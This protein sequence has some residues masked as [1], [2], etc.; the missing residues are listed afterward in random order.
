MAAGLPVPGSRLLL[1]LLLALVLLITQAFPVTSAYADEPDNPV[2]STPSK[3]GTSEDNPTTDTQDSQYPA[4]SP[5]QSDTGTE[6]EPGSDDDSAK[7]ADKDEDNAI[8]NSDSDSDTAA[9]ASKELSSSVPADEEESQPDST[10]L[11]PEALPQSPNTGT[12]ISPGTYYLQPVNSFLRVLDVWGASGAD[13]AKVCL[14]DYHGG[15]NQRFTVSQDAQGYYTITNTSSKKALDVWGALAVSGASV[16]QY[17][18]HNNANQ[19]WYAVEESGGTYSFHTALGLSAGKDLAL[20]V[21]GGADQNAANLTIYTYHKGQNQL[22]RLVAADTG[23]T[24]PDP[25]VTIDAQSYYAIVPA[26]AEGKRLDIYGGM[27]EV[28]ARLSSYRY[29][30]GLN[31]IFYFEQAKQQSGYYSIRAANSTYALDIYGAVAHASANVV[32]WPAH[33]G[34]NQLWA[35]KATGTK[36]ADG[37]QEVYILSAQVGQTLDVYGSSTADGAS[38]MAY[39]YHG[40]KNQRFV[41]INLGST[42]PAAPQ[43]VLGGLYSLVPTISSSQALD[44]YGANTNAG[45]K[46]VNWSAHS[47]LNQV[48]YLRGDQEG[49]YSFENINSGLFL[50]EKDGKIVQDT[51]SAT[52]SQKWSYV[53]ERGGY[54]LQN[55]ASDNCITLSSTNAGTQLVAAKSNTQSPNQG[56]LFYAAQINI[57]GY[58]LIQSASGKAVDVWGSSYANGARVSAYSPHSGNNQKWYAQ[59][60]GNSTYSFKAAYAPRYLDVYNGSADSGTQAQTWEYNGSNSQKWQLAYEGG[61]WFSLKSLAG[62]AYLTVSGDNMV[63]TPRSTGAAATDSQRFRFVGTTYTPPQYI[64]TYADV[65]LTTQRMFFIKDGKK[66]LECD[67]VTGAPSMATPPGTFTL[68]YKTGPTVLRGPGYASPVSYWMPFNGGI[69]FHDA[70]WQSAFGGNRYLT[71]GSHGC[72]NMPLWAAEILYRNISAGDK[73][74]VHR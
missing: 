36:R 72:I 12:A 65:N 55:K 49:Y 44:V 48:F 3:S 1:S 5:E 61:G 56:I 22:F 35:L 10:T 21:W 16:S 69:G 25:S 58:Y 71:H 8:P 24:L 52:D 29:G 33:A 42:L 67:I 37:N 27:S 60:H 64:G 74:V 7:A 2:S 20:D 73:V 66:I 23:I 47:S 62:N 14:Y 59:S 13:G 40:G 46:V 53:S 54:R 19:K 68:K 43:P 45:A 4:P 63:V 9:T 26:Y 28:G 41:L 70:T 18:S 50:A 34:Q 15:S 57:N 39:P 31:Q 30:S 51:G 6:Q 38:V 11:E 17:K 32:Q